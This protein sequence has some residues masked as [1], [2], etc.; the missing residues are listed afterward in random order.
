M[1]KKRKLELRIS[2]YWH[3]DAKLR[4]VILNKIKKLG[5]FSTVHIE[6]FRLMPRKVIEDITRYIRPVFEI[7]PESHDLRIRR[8]CQRAA[9]TN[10]KLELWLQE[11]LELNVKRIEVFFMI[12]LPGQTENS[13]MKT[14]KYCEYLLEKFKNRKT[15]VPFMS[16]MIPFLNPAS[17]AFEKPEQYGYK[18]FYKTVKEHAEA[19]TAVSL[20]NRLN[21]KTKW[22]S[23]EQIIDATY[24]SSRQLTL[25]KVRYGYLPQEFGNDIISRLDKTFHLKDVLDGIDKIHD[26]KK[27]LKALGD[28]AGSVRSYNKEIM[29]G[30]F[31][32]QLPIDLS[33][34]D[35]WYEI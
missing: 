16:A 35:F 11:A 17:A 32:D 24:K 4:T 7:S 31:C 3:E 5:F 14:A 13:V 33:L 28:I 1:P 6:L 10:R 8:L 25:A 26:T 19:L 15:V 12:G 21:Y 2:G 18:V 22:M 34:Y 27:R 20:K 29:K 9:Y 23:R 30:K